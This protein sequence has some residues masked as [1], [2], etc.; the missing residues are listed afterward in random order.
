[1]RVSQ[2]TIPNNSQ[3]RT[4]ALEMERF[5]SALKPE[6][7]SEHW[8]PITALLQKVSSMQVCLP[9]H[10]LP[11][12]YV[13]EHITHALMISNAITELYPFKSS[14][15]HKQTKTVPKRTKIEP[16]ESASSLTLNNENIV[17]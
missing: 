10:C 15:R 9:C 16:F 17:G 6:L 3:S 5:G 12:N 2:M 7:E 1:M 14:N 13:C 11:F 8:S 4:E